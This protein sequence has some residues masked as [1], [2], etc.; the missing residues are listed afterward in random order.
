MRNGARRAGPHSTLTRL[1]FAALSTVLAVPAALVLSGV[2]AVAETTSIV[3]QIGTT[4]DDSGQAVAT[5][6]SGNIYVAG[7]TG[8]VLP[9]QTK[10][11]TWDGFLRK[12]SSSG[13]VRWTV[14]FGAADVMP[15]ALAVD[16]SGNAYVAGYVHGAFSDCTP[17]PCSPAGGQDA[18]VRQYKAD[19]ELGWTR[20]FGSASLDEV[21][22][23]AVG[24]GYVY[25][26]G[27]TQGA[28]PGYEN[29][30]NVEMSY[31]RQF[32]T[33]DGKEGWTKQFGGFN[34]DPLN[35]DWYSET[36][37]F[38]L[39]T[40][41]SGN[42]YASGQSDGNMEGCAPTECTWDGAHDDGY[43]RQ[44]SESGTLG[45][46]DWITP[47]PDNEVAYVVL[48]TDSSGNIDA[49]G[50]IV[51]ALP[52]QTSSGGEDEFV[53]QYDTTGATVWTRQFGTSGNEWVNWIAAAPGGGF[54]IIDHV[55]D[56]AGERAFAGD[57]SELWARTFG[58]PTDDLHTSGVAVAP[59]GD[60]YVAGSTTTALPGFANAG[61]WDAF[62]A[63]FSS[64]AAVATSTE[65]TAAPEPSLTG[66]IVTY[67]A[68][69]T[70]SSGILDGGTVTFAEGTTTLCDA[71]ALD[72][73]TRQATCD[74][75]YGWAASHVVSAV[76]SGTLAFDRSW[77]YVTHTVTNG[78]T[79]DVVDQFGSSKDDYGNRVATDPSGNV[80]IA[81]QT[82]GAL[83]GQTQ[84]G[85]WDAFVRKYAGNGDVL[86][87]RQFG[88]NDT[89]ITGLAVDSTGDVYVSGY[90]A[91]AL[92][93]CTP[94]LCSYAGG[95]D[96]FVRQYKANGDLRWTQEFG[97]IA[98]EEAETL[99]VSSGYVYVGGY[100][101]GAFPGYE[102][103]GAVR[104]AYIRQF[105]TADGSAGWTRQFGGF[106][107]DPWGGWYSSTEVY[108]LATDASGN[109]Y[110]GGY[111]NGNMDGCLPTACTSDSESAN[112]NGFIR[113]YSQTGDVGW[114]AW[115][116][117]PSDGDFDWMQLATDSSGKVDAAGEIYGALPGQD[118][119]GSGD[120]FVAQYD[121]VSGAQVWMHEFGTAE[122]DSVSGIATGPGGGVYIAELLAGR[123][124]AREFTS[125]G[126]EVWSRTF[127]AV[128][129]IYAHDIALDGTGNAFVVGSSEFALPGFAGAGMW[130]A[131]LLEFTSSAAEATSTE[132][133]ASSETSTPGAQV[134]YTATVTAS[135]GILDGGTVTFAEGTTT[136]CNAVAV[137]TGT[138]Q[139]TCEVTYSSAGSHVVSAAYSGTT[140]F[141]LS[142]GY[143]QHEVSV[144]T[145]T[146]LA[147]SAEP[148]VIG[149]SV[150][151]TATVTPASGTLDG[152]T[153]T[154]TQGSSAIC[155]GMAVDTATGHAT[156]TRPYSTLGTYSLTAS[157]SGTTSFAGSIS[158]PYSHKVGYGVS[159]ISKLTTR[160]GGTVKVKLQLVNAAG[161]NVSA[162][163]IT[164]TVTGVSPSWGSVTG[165]FS[166]YPRHDPFYQYQVTVP[167]TAGRGTYQ[168]T[169]TATGD[170][171]THVVQFTVR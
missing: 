94:E 43:V 37:V 133:S 121:A 158:S 138:R 154:F 27:L 87:T 68:T 85:A 108:S 65:V 122:R 123:A 143:A 107:P 171:V 81:G 66:A 110:A 148:S 165:S 74:V 20:Q 18:F 75:T 161:S 134:T 162:S 11:G 96:A 63:E 83:P 61:G 105:A 153:V 70:P 111:S 137:D 89:D 140:S 5:D 7:Q 21:D 106:N 3:D 2:P 145:S 13:V 16:A 54:A 53:R 69:V 76:Y 29:P 88:E 40:D 56:H 79:T 67:T 112:K 90:V 104:M 129:G 98:D 84:V 9:G 113:Q 6:P 38:S 95:R 169:F 60:V 131:Y 156:C 62:L 82:N 109:L 77:G 132:L 160:P 164:L 118:Y 46:T 93:G 19:G 80:V 136:L 64:S 35:G 49:G 15:Y 1:V 117:A 101:Y 17:D 58:A 57:G 39:T 30:D 167:K 150:T 135:S 78:T 86:W 119:A 92:P 22:A 103:P 151:Y 163:T 166:F 155:T 128:D 147:A 31:I 168:L 24:S 51:G 72:P 99:A 25:A 120:E 4:G 170:P 26:G 91:G 52:G 50:G 14:Q 71:V 116:T 115:L 125:A 97:T 149:G 59:T 141:D 55:D 32:A 48:T 8:G 44:Y 47:G 41:A 157:Y 126:S 102:N 152:G 130:D 28:L 10:V 45:W 139:A 127:G 100:T 12:Y 23:L 124:G 34:P 42:V 73:V 114:T 33:T 144:A 146:T 36:Q 142:W 159:G